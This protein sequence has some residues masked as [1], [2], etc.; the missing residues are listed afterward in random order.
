MTSVTVADSLVA[1]IRGVAA[2][3]PGAV[4][5]V[6]D[7]AGRVLDQ[8]G[9]AGAS[10]GPAFEVR[11]QGGLRAIARLPEGCDEAE[12]LALRVALETLARCEELEAELRSMDDGSAKLMEQ[13][14]LLHETLP[15]LSSADS[16]EEVVGRGLSACMTATNVR[17][18]VYVERGR[19]GF[20]HVLAHFERDDAGQPLATPYPLP[21]RVPADRGIVGK[22]LSNGDRSVWSTVSSSAEE[23]DDLAPESLCVRQIL[24]VPVTYCDGANTETLGAILLFD[25]TLRE[26]GGEERGLGTDDQQLANTVAVM[27][28]SVL[29]VRR[30]AE[31][32]KELSMAHEIQAQILPAS[33]ARVPGFDVAGD[34]RS[35]GDVGGDYF[36]Y[37]PL[38]DGRT[39]AVIADVSGHN[40][41]S[42]MMMVSARATLRTLAQIHRDPAKLFTELGA[43]MHQDLSRTERFITA[44]GVAMDPEGGAI[45]IV[46]AGHNPPMLYR[47]KDR[48]VRAIESDSTVLGFLPDVAYDSVRVELE[49]GDC[50]LLYTDGVTEATNGDDDMFGEDRLQTVLAASAQRGASDV[51]A[52]VMAS[53]HAFR[54]P[55][56]S[57]DDITLVAI[58]RAGGNKGARKE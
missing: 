32:G 45:E 4:V 40:L 31:F 25:T 49:P 9:T 46:N 34:Y 12:A 14:S 51:V 8:S 20:A 54:K 53:V 58:R 42:G 29:G 15:N 37:V 17:R 26:D 13:I 47:S 50:L 10:S 3:A 7:A 18:A 38:Q 57:G 22:A 43:S 5:C 28:G 35:W 6:L 27:L 55:G 16:T 39:L 2:A 52:M 1:R 36:D 24:A 48:T 11:F 44:A 56:Q 33:A 41:A 21:E 30:A 23:R 19:D